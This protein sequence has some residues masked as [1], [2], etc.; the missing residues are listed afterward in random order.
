MPIVVRGTWH[1]NFGVSL[2]LVCS[3]SVTS[4]ELSRKNRDAA[5]Y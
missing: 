4:E 2:P 5:I 3:N 1:D